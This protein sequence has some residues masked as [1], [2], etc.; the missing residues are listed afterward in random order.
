MSTEFFNDQWR[1]PS[2][3]NQNKVSNYSMEFNGTSDFI[4]VNNSSETLNVD[5]ISISAWY[6][7]T[8][9]VSSSA[10]ISTP[11][12]GSG[13]HSYSILLTSSGN[14]RVILY[15]GA[16]FDQTFTSAGALN[17]NQWNFICM[18]YDGAN[19]KVTLNTSSQSI[20][21]TGALQYT[22][23]PTGN[24][25]IGRRNGNSSFLITGNLDQVSIFDYGL[26]ATQV[27][28][29]YGGGTAITNPMSLSPAP[30]AYYQLGDQSVDNGANY[31]VPNNSLSDYVFNFDGTSSKVD[32]AST[33][34]G[35]SN[36]ISFWFYWPSSGNS[37]GTFIGGSTTTN[38]GLRS[39]R[40]IA[41]VG[42]S[43]YFSFDAAAFVWNNPWSVT[44]N[45]RGD[46]WNQIV[47]VRDAS[48]ADA[49]KIQ[50][51]INNSTL[52]SYNVVYFATPNFSTQTNI[53]NSIGQGF[54]GASPFEGF[55]SNVSTFTTAFTQAQVNTLYNNG[56]PSS[57]ISSL[58]PVNWWKLNAQD[59]FDG[60]NWTINDYGS[61]G[62]D[63][64][65][66]GMNLSNLV[67]SD[68]QQASGYSPYALDFDGTD[69]GNKFKLKLLH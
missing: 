67:V 24:I 3:E 43:I 27:S 19:V 60:T 34:L 5:F 52:T 57:D 29:L 21:R 2:N 42:N 65:S 25:E 61:G 28:T 49:D 40:A 30:V 63:G 35:T 58:S 62:N 8:S 14:L 66:S 9:F 32:I 36:T 68:L 47:I 56:Q 39:G 20:A 64:T 6:Y 38:P 4:S 53:A 26:S 31:L 17:L 54:S 69:Q 37:S 50:L 55:I 16:N 18:T 48:K 1:I 44:G 59:T 23:N 11:N 33:S 22:V 13:Y 45:T 7:P 46:N 51:S 15:T 10:I 41:M 12:R